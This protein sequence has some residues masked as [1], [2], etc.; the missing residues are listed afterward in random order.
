MAGLRRAAKRVA[1][2]ILHEAFMH[3]Q[4]GREPASAPRVMMFPSNDPWDAASNLRTWLVAPELRALGWRVTVVPPALGLEQR[5]RAVRLERPDVIF[6]QQT[7]H[8]LNQPKLYA[9]CPVVLDAD[10]ADCLDSRLSDMIAESARDAAAVVGGST[11]IADWM[12]R[13]NP[14]TEV[15]WSCSPPPRT[16]PAR[17]WRDR[18]PIV[19][20]A[21]AAP[22][23]YE[24]EA[25]LIHRALQLAAA[26]ARFSFWLFGTTEAEA[27][28]WFAPLRR[29]GVDCAA[30]SPLRYDGYLLKVAESAI[31]LQPVCTT[32]HPFS[33]GK[34][35]G[36]VLAYLCGGVAVIASNDVDHPLFFDHRAN[37][38]LVDSQAEQWADGIVELVSDPA[39]RCALAERGRADFLTRLTTPTFARLLTPI[40]QRA[41]ART[42]RPSVL[43]KV[44][45]SAA[46]G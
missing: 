41:A 10:D 4:R 7:R 23:R 16:A 5:R 27:R 43:P 39:L 22:F 32:T 11:F 6:M 34:S 24:E 9:P 42:A 19:A 1:K 37:G 28:D 44:P 25:A 12:R 8:P 36:K 13:H 18:A 17:H 20:W 33:R 46:A 35:F 14:N 40:L 26:R 2:A 45:S 29:A 3:V 31:G 21:H 38:L 30:I 15:I